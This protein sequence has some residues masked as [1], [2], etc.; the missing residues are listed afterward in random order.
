[1]SVIVNVAFGALFLLLTFEGVIL[2]SFIFLYLI[3]LVYPPKIK[4]K[5]LEFTFFTLQELQPKCTAKG[6]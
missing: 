6:K 2:P 1:M 3:S 4:K 5:N